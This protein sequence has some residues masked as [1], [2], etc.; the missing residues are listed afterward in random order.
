ML[1]RNTTDAKKDNKLHDQLLILI[2]RFITID[3]LKEVA[4]GMNTLMNESFNNSVGGLG[5]TQKQ[6]VFI[7]QFA[8]TPN[9][10]GTCN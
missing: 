5:C 7:F 1:K 8:A 3:A 4:H 9:C 6:S 10:H 2:E